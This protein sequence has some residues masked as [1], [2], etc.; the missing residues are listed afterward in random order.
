MIVDEEHRFGAADKAK[1]KALG[2]G[3]HVLTLSA[4]PIP[5]TL[6]AALVGLQDLSMIATPP[7]R[8]RPIRTFTEPL[9]PVTIKAALRRERGRGGQSFVVVPR[10]E[11]LEP[12]RE[13]LTA[14]APELKLVAAHGKMAAAEVDEAMV[15]FAQGRGDVLLATNIIESGLDVPRANT[16]LICDADRFGLAQ[17][18]QLR[19]RVGRGRAQGVCYLFTDPERPPAEGTLSRLR[20]LS[21]FDRLGAGMAISA[22]DL[23]LRGAGELLGDAQAGHVNLIGL[24][25]YQHLLELAIRTARG[26]TVE[27]WT[28]D[29]RI[30]Q[31]GAL[32]VDYVP[33]EGL[34]LNLYARL[35]RVLEP[36]AVDALA[37]ELE[38][39]FGPPP[40][41]VAQLLDLARLRSLCLRWGVARIDAGPH[42]IAY[43]LRAN[44]TGRPALEALVERASGLAWKGERL[45]QP[46]A[47][48]TSGERLRLALEL[49]GDLE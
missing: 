34:R 37:D 10:I 32:P 1:L 48:A 7:A 11:D 13:R 8:R 30:E 17:L 24:G 2:R 16:V 5:R 9:D 44:S 39:R 19:G 40:P 35:A 29:I 45:I 41:E 46:R 20:A 6:Q 47:T 31:S 43:T 21:A 18:H 42:A 25:L 15:A 3:V 22:R 38:D 36:E 14:L 49:L 28:P 26:E 23:D 12:M 27:D 33:E 4:T